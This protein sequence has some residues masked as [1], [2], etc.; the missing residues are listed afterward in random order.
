MHVTINH[1]RTYFTIPLA[2]RPDE[3]PCCQERSRQEHGQRHSSRSGGCA[4]ESRKTLGRVAAATSRSQP[5]ELP[6]TFNFHLSRTCWMLI[7]T[8]WYSHNMAHVFPERADYVWFVFFG[9]SP[10]N[11]ILKV[12]G[13][14]YRFSLKAFPSTQ[15]QYWS[16]W[17]SV[18]C[19]TATV[20]AP[21]NGTTNPTGCVMHF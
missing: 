4:E 2:L 14:A 9:R 1:V 8:M 21:T 5:Q 16:V 18:S 10:S 6:W 17:N 3:A 15:T 20:R 12:T 7:I 19:L 11:W 13:T